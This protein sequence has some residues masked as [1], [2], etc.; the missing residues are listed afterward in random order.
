MIIHKL[1]NGDEVHRFDRT[2][3]IPFKGKRKVLST[4]AYNGGYK[5]NIKVVYNNDG[6]FGLGVACKM[7]GSNIEEHEKAIMEEIGFDLD[8]TVGMGTAAFM[9]NVSI[10]EK[11]FEDISVTAIVTGGIEANGGRIGDPAIYKGGEQKTDFKVGT[12]NIILYFNV[13]MPAGAMARALVSCTEG[14]TA[15]LQE[16]LAPSRYSRGIATGSGTDSTIIVADSESNSF[17]RDTGTH[18]KLGELIGITVKEAVKEALFLQT[19]LCEKYQYNS[20]NRLERF[21]LKEK[22]IFKYFKENYTDELE[23]PEF[24]NYL[25]EI[26]K[27]RDNL[28]LTSL[29][30]HLIDQMDWNLIS[31][32]DTIFGVNELF[33]NYMDEKSLD[34]KELI[35]EEENKDKLVEKILE[36]WNDIVISEILYRRKVEKI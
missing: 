24:S 29:V 4:A 35:L 20:L 11:T 17:Y 23:R 25:E 27:S 36:D 8:T 26:C 1:P 19:G 15:A 12:I 34:F 7:R 28:I 30:A 31:V 10:K 21:G 6:N 2:I 18:S 14:K 13:D 5:E 16:L 3:A 9:E 33:K 22:E 32:E